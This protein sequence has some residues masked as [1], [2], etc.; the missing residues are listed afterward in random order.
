MI[1]CL[2]I[3]ALA[4]LQVWS[5]PSFAQSFP[6]RPIRVV[7][8]FDAGGAMDVVIRIIGKRIADMGGP[9]ILV[10]NKTG[11]GGAIG[12]MA[13]KEAAPDGY[14]LVEISS[15]THVLNPHTSANIPYDPV[16]DFQPVAMLATLPT[17]VAVPGNMPVNSLA[18]LL[19]L[20]RQ[21]PGGLS[22]GSAGVGSAPHIAAA[23]LARSTGTPMTHVPYR[24]LAGALNDIVGGRIDFV[25]GSIPSFG[26]T[27]ADGKVKLLAVSGSK[28][29]KNYPLL[30]SMSEL[31]HAAVNV[32]LW[33]GLAAP[34]GTDT[35]IVR[36]LNEL[37]VKATN[38]P[39]LEERF[40]QL[41]VV[42]ATS[43]PDQFKQTIES[44]NARLGPFVKELMTKQN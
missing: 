14:T 9:Q 21:K 26:G 10:E 35:A 31:G 24:G 37:F 36:M 38:S 44:E 29:V 28:R 34:A 17:F 4:A 12:V 19:A 5:T 42:I 3:L 2:A 30:P 8:P 18:D 33:I 15:S 32:D 13:V 25:F 40:A 41:G 43:T 7:V 16:K 6:N 22:Y 23:L 20:A 11:A 27:V 39:E 1:R